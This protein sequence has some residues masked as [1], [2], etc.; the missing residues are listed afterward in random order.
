MI[1]VLFPA[2]AAVQENPT[3]T[4]MG[5]G[6]VTVPTDAVTI[7]ATVEGENENLTGRR[8]SPR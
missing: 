3:L 4:A 5:E 8:A 6:T 1:R 2:C 7:I